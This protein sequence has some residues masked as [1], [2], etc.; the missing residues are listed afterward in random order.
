MPF[1]AHAQLLSE[2]H[3]SFWTSLFPFLSPLPVA[4]HAAL[5]AEGHCGKAF[6]TFTV[7]VVGRSADPTPVVRKL[8]FEQLSNQ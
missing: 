3:I 8:Q 4:D 1:G 2:D 5:I 6:A 7:N